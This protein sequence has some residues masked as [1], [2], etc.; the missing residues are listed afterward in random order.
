MGQG[1]VLQGE[2]A[3]RNRIVMVAHRHRNDAGQAAY[4][5]SLDGAAGQL[6]SAGIVEEKL[7]M[8]FLDVGVAMPS[9]SGE[10][11]EVPRGVVVG[12]VAPLFEEGFL[13][14]GCKL[15]C[16]GVFPGLEKLVVVNLTL[17]PVDRL[18]VEDLT[19]FVE[20]RITRTPKDAAGVRILR[21]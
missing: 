15:Y 20:G 2:P 6:S 4:V 9:G 8:T 18:I 5:F 17:P 12:K 11:I 21:G 16:Q 7:T 3:G 10:K 13:E 19:A 14:E 1:E